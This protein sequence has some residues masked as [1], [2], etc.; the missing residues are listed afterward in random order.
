[1]WGRYF[2]SSTGPDESRPRITAGS[3]LNIIAAVGAVLLFVFTENMRNPVTL[4]DQWTP[5]MLLI[6]ALA[7]LITSFAERRKT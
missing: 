2:S 5:F 3:L 6:F 4:R 7:L 1:M